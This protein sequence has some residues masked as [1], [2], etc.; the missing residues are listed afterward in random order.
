MRLYP[1]ELVLQDRECL[2]VGG[3]K[4]AELKAISLL[5]A[6]A[7]LL[8]ISPR[9]TDW[10]REAAH[11]SDLR[12]EKRSYQ[13]GDLAKAFLVVVATERPEVNELVS[14]EAWGAGILCNVVDDPRRCSFVVPAVLRRGDFSVSVSTGG[15]SPLLARRIREK[16]EGMFGT[17]YE[18]YMEFLGRMRIRAKER[19]RDPGDKDVFF[20]ELLT[21]EYL[22][23]F[24][25]GLGQEAEEKAE[26]M[27]HTTD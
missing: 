17:E 12:W 21:E 19:L 11:R 5:E 9:V 22:E 7:S 20:R 27:F 18:S 2:L 25:R 13:S 6:G 14:R 23:L 1:V 24:R 3:G 16:L 10:I 15:N 26:A 8:V 4:V